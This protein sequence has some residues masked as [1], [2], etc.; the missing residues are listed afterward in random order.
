MGDIPIAY[1]EGIGGVRVAET[2][3]VEARKNDVGVLLLV[4]L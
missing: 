2:D 3:I 1:I 4:C